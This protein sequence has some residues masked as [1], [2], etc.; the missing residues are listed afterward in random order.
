MGRRTTV[1]GVTVIAAP[2]E[3]GPAAVGIVADRSVGNAVVRNRARRRLRAAVA[4]AGPPP[5]TD[6]VVLATS[7]V[8]GVRFD[9]LV[10]WVRRAL[11][12]EED[13]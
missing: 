12:K 2:G 8:V 3:P 7:Q 13:G 4:E 6:L 9:E 5:G 1:G 10:G 11:P